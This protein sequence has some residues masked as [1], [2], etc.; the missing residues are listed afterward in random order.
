M[1][2]RLQDKRVQCS[3][4]CVSCNSNYEDLAH[5]LFKCPFVMQVWQM[6]GIWSEVNYAFLVTNSVVEAIFSLLQIYLKNMPSV[7]QPFAGAYGS[8]A[9]LNSGRMR[10]NCVPT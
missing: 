3:M 2:V 8:T 7:W 1:R 4:T 10:M 9:T 6:T 5:I